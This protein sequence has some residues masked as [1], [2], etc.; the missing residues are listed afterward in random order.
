MSTFDRIVE[1]FFHKELNQMFSIRKKKKDALSKN[2]G[3][4]VKDQWRTSIDLYSTWQ[5]QHY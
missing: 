1:Q 4:Y 2:Y 5:N 3:L